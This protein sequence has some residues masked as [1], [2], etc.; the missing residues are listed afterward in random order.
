MDR[1]PSADEMRIL[2][3]KERRRVKPQDVPE[4]DTEI[5]KRIKEQTG[6]PR[7]LINQM[8]EEQSKKSL[9]KLKVKGRRVN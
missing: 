9:R 1:D 4:P 3:K 7:K 8:V 6:L 2:I 5:G